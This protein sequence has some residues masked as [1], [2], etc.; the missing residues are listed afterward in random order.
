MPPCR[1]NLVIGPKIENYRLISQYAL[2]PRN[3]RYFWGN[4]NSIL[5]ATYK[6]QL[7]GLCMFILRLGK[8][9][10]PKLDHNLRGLCV[11]FFL[12]LNFFNG[13]NK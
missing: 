13:F 6:T 11:A 2:R 8:P 5:V 12:N 4:A 7:A 3:L 10:K 1:R 9:I